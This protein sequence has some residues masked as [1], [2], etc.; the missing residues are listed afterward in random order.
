MSRLAE[1][2]GSDQGVPSAEIRGEH[3]NKIVL[4]EDEI[5]CV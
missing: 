3:A 4:L 2:E 5:I 1:K